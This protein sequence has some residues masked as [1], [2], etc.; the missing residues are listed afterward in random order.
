MIT[1]KKFKE[2]ENEI[3]DAV[4]EAVKEACF[5]PFGEEMEISIMS[6]GSVSYGSMSSNSKSWDSDSHDNLNYYIGGCYGNSDLFDEYEYVDNIMEEFRNKLSDMDTDYMKEKIVEWSLHNDNDEIAKEV[7][8]EIKKEIAEEMNIEIEHDVVQKKYLE[9][10]NNMTL[11]EIYDRIRVKI[12][13]KLDSM[14]YDDLFDK[15]I[16]IVEEKESDSIYSLKMLFPGTYE[17]IIEELEKGIADEYAWEE[18]LKVMEIIEEEIW[19]S[20]KT[21]SLTGRN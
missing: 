10:I 19:R 5:L 12:K 18:T 3:F 17:E 15:I 2:K 20:D 1:L 4:Y 6:D 14:D 8:K 7:D 9:K 13:E 16:E 21:I 11:T